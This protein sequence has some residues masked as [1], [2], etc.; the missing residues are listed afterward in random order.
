MIY[1]LLNRCI[2]REKKKVQKLWLMS[3]FKAV[4]PGIGWTVLKVDPRNQRPLALS[5]VES[6][7]NSVAQFML[8]NYDELYGCAVLEPEG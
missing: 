2:E 6:N 1:Q 5:I 3:Y 4:S 7:W 8:P